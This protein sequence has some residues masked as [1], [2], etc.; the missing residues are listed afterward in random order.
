MGVGSRSSGQRGSHEQRHG[1]RSIMMQS[2]KYK[3][4]GVVGT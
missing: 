4:S 1:G 2:G 3:P